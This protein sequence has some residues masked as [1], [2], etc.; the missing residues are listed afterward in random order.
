MVALFAKIFGSKAADLAKAKAEIAE[1]IPVVN[2]SDDD[3]CS[4][5][6]GACTT[7]FPSSLKLSD[8]DDGNT[9]LWR[10][11]AN[12]DLHCV[13]PTGKTDWI[14]DATDVRG[15]VKKQIAEWSKSNTATKLVGKD[16]ERGSI[17]VSTSSLPLGDEMDP[18]YINGTKADVLLLP[19]FVWVHGLTVDKVDSVLTEV[20]DILQ[21]AQEDKSGDDTAEL[22][23]ETTKLAIGEAEETTTLLVGETEEATKLPVGEVQGFAVKACG[24]QSHIFLCSH[25]TR[26][27]RCGITAPIMKREMEDILRDKD[28]LRDYGDDRAGGV[29]V[30][31]VN[32]VGG[33]K[34]TANVMIYKKNGDMIWLARCHPKNVQLILEE[35]VLGK[36]RVWAEKVRLVQKTNP[37]AW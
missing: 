36:G 26:D 7:S 4:M 6:C 18:A 14:R 8:E 16:G 35:S 27:K 3:T 15:T 11:T 9:V 2:E 23:G 20:V 25:Q 12:Y 28:L 17:K 5:D 32:H 37:I 21:K 30:S 33:H 24:F 19:Y 22:A 31:F 10:S 29:K 34:Y 1:I 13:V